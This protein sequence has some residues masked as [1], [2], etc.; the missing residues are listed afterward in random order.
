VGPRSGHPQ[1]ALDADLASVAEGQCVAQARQRARTVVSI[2]R[3]LGKAL[4]SGGRDYQRRAGEL[5]PRLP[6]LMDR[7]DPLTRFADVV[8]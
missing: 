2:E 5:A 6:R 1:P 7:N 3:S 4:M 8:P